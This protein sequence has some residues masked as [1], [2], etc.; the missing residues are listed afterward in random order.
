MWKKYERAESHLQCSLSRWITIVVVVYSLILY[1]KR[2][3]FLKN[4][5]QSFHQ[6]ANSHLI[7]MII[8]R[9]DERF[10]FHIV[11]FQKVYMPIQEYFHHATI[12]NN[13]FPLIGWL[14][15]KW[16][17]KEIPF[18]CIA[19]DNSL[20]EPNHE[21]IRVQM[22]PSQFQWI[23]S[24]STAAQQ[25]GDWNR[26]WLFMLLFFSPARSEGKKRW[27]KVSSQK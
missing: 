26:I 9:N 4:F 8:H 14:R 25:N 6:V 5:L 7:F 2:E 11:I 10:F 24:S 19:Y 13:R 22:D 3:Q 23:H 18:S 17:W 16:S 15:C 21:L 1:P 27:L 20:Q 12:N